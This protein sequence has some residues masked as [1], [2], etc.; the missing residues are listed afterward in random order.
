MTPAN[1]GMKLTRPVKIGAL[2]LI[3]SVRQ[4]MKG[5]GAE[6]HI[7]GAQQARP[8]ACTSLVAGVTLRTLVRR[9]EA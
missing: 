3:P 7:N 1:K 6:R 5:E 4:I 8:G 2:Q 9:T